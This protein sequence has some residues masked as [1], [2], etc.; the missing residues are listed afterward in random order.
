MSFASQIV[1]E[2]RGLRGVIDTSDR[3]TIVD[4]LVF[5]YHL[6]LASGPMLKFGAAKVAP[7]TYRDFLV[8]HAE[9]ENDHAE[10][11]AT[12][13]HNA[14]ESLQNLGLQCDAAY[15]AGAQYYLTFHVSPYAL[16]GYMLVLECFPMQEH[17]VRAL[18]VLHGQAL[19]TTLRYHSTHDVEHGAEVLRQI[20]DMPIVYRGLVRQNA[21]RTVRALAAVSQRFG[22]HPAVAAHGAA[23]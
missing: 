7:G 14:G 16:L 12:D 13:F 11:L 21:L 1:N 18:E 9:E 23:V 3:R 22:A 20:D 4:N 17:E 10:W 6:I 15:V 8:E 19:F 2:V 5:A